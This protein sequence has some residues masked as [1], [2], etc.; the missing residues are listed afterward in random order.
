MEY[1]NHFIHPTKPR[2][3]FPVPEHHLLAL[4]LL[5]TYYSCMG[6]KLCFR[7]DLN[8]PRSLFSPSEN[9]TYNTSMFHERK[10]Q[11]KSICI[12]LDFPKFNLS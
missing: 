6:Q 4:S 11:N 5:T 7:K 12:Q 3:I 10:F 9:I 8:I 1:R 2:K